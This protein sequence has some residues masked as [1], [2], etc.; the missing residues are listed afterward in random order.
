MSERPR[1]LP[2]FKKAF[3]LFLDELHN[4]FSERDLEERQVT[5]GLRTKFHQIKGAAGMFGLPELET[6]AAGIEDELKRALRCG[7]TPNWAEIERMASLLR[8]EVDR[9]EAMRREDGA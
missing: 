1:I 7:G 3:G 6:P 4:V 5:E 8:A 2:A 9:L